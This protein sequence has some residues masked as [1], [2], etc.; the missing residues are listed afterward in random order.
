LKY[1]DLNQLLAKKPSPPLVAQNNW[2]TQLPSDALD[3]IATDFLDAQSLVTLGSTC[4]LFRKELRDMFYWREK[5]IA[6]GCPQA[7]LKPLEQTRAVRDYKNLHRTLAK[8]SNFQVNELW[9]LLCLSGEVTALQYAIQHANLTSDTKNASGEKASHFVALSGN[10]ASFQFLIKRFNIKKPSEGVDGMNESHYAAMSGNIE[11][12]DKTIRHFKI[13]PTSVNQFGETLAHFAAR[14]HQFAALKHV[15]T[16]YKLKPTIRTSKNESLLHACVNNVNMLKQV[17]QEYNLDPYSM[18]SDN[19]TLLH[20][21]AKAG[22][23]EGVQ[24]VIGKYQ[25]DPKQKDKFGSTLLH[26][27][28]GNGCVAMMK[29]AVDVLKISPA[30]IIQD[31]TNLLQLAAL[32]GNSEAVRYAFELSESL[33]LD[34][35]A[36]Q[37]NHEN[38]SA[39]DFAKNGPNPEA[40]AAL[41]EN[42][43]K[44]TSSLSPSYLC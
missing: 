20:V 38:Q 1:F 36:E 40:I 30:E 12:I 9:E 32:S 13:D 25:I 39:F 31:G 10:V 26:Y 27:A 23:I 5:L 2:L 15:I 8:L 18:D 16:T 34:W 21:T 17:I 24:Y 4:C 22:N 29:F 28:T 42:Y 37:L 35:R 41:L 14:S 11:C 7:F 44:E 43:S 6:A 33:H 3:K 19:A